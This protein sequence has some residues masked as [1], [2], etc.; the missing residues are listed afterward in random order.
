VI[1]NIDTTKTSL[2]T[3]II[4]SGLPDVNISSVGEQWSFKFTESYKEHIADIKIVHKE[5]I[6][7]KVEIAIDN[8]SYLA[9]DLF[10]IETPLY[11]IVCH[12]LFNAF[13]FLD[14]PI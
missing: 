6:A 5:G 13:R 9:Y 2:I 4:N 10:E 3:Q 8:A 1:N 11:D 14:R 12:Y 7:L